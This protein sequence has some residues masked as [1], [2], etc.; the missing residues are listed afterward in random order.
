MN[1]RPVTNYRK[2][3]PYADIHEDVTQLRGPQYLEVY[4]KVRRII[5]HQFNKKVRGGIKGFLFWGEVG[6]GKTAMGKALAKD[7]SCPLIFVDG[8]DIA[9]ALY[10]QSEQA[11]TE[12]FKNPG[13]E[14][15]LILIDDAESVFPRRNW[16]KGESWHIAQ[17]NV[18]F[19]ELDTLDTSNTIVILT[20][21]EVGLMD[22]AIRD[23]LYEIEFPLPSKEVL[24]EIAKDKCDEL[25]IP[26]QKVASGIKANDR[27]KTIRDVEKLVLEHY[28]QEVI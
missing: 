13:D 9:R 6:I 18:L 7:I 16:V 24:V 5:E 28:A 17:N 10:G 2:L 22:K 21:N 14:R 26:W 1:K 23:R 19:H 11:I 27:V 25:M 3:N 12:I 8:S 15:R 4:Y 20:T